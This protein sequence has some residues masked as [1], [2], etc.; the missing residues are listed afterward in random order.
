MRTH[1]LIA[2]LLSVSVDIGFVCAADGLPG[3]HKFAFERLSS[4]LLPNPIRIHPRVISGGLPDGDRAFAE[5]KSLGVKT[6]ISV[7][8]AKP[9]LATAAKYGIRYVH[10]PHGYDGIPENR[11]AELAKA[12]R[13]LPGPIYIHCHHG[14]HRSPAAAAVACVGAGLIQPQDA[15]QILQ[16]AGTS[17]H[18]RGL[19]GSAQAAHPLDQEL[20]D[21]LPAEFPATAKIPAM[22]EVMVGIEHTHDHLKQLEKNGWRSLATKPDLTSE[23]EALLLRE[24][25]TELLRTPEVQKQPAEFQQLLKEAVAHSQKLEDTLRAGSQSKNKNAQQSASATFQRVT[26]NCRVCHERFRDIPLSEKLGRQD[27]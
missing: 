16:V 1:Y 3:D 23:H 20:L 17:E 26:E 8:G 27:R 11:A 5:L 13:D 15:L 18:Y 4:E 7:D 22:A 9:D 25:F 21:Q 24:H 14:K 10:L 12:V 6:I 2:V 19:F